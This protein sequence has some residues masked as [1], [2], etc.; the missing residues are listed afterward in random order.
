M[1]LTQINNIANSQYAKEASNYIKI[2]NEL[3]R[4]GA[5]FVVNL[6]TIVFYGNQSASK[7]SLLETISGVKK[8]YYYSPTTVLLIESP[9]SWACPVSL[10]KEYMMVF[11]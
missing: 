2:L 4:V 6:P 3:R 5:H 8:Y 11:H 1:T 10:R 9:E 7:S